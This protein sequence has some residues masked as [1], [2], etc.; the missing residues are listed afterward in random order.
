[1]YTSA[2][3][4]RGKDL[5]PSDHYPRIL[6]LEP[7][8]KCN[9]RCRNETCD[10]AN[11]ATVHLRREDF[12]PWRLF[13]K[14]MDE[15][16]PHIEDL[17]F[18]N[19][20]EPFV[21]PKALDML[22]Y[23][24]KANPKLR[25][26]TSTNGILLARDG[27]AERIVQEELIDWI[28][29]TIGG[30]DQDTY[31][32]YHKS[33]SFEKAILGMRRLIEQKRKVGKTTPTVHW[34]YLI[35]HWND[36]DAHIAEALRLREEIGVDEFKFML[37]S[38]PLAGRS[39]RRAPGT[40]GFDAIKPWLAYQDDYRPD[41]FSE[42][43]FWGEERNGGFGA[44]R[45]TGKQ[46]KF[47]VQPTD[48]RVNIRLARTDVPMVPLPD[49]RLRLPWGEFAADIGVGGH[50][51]VNAIPVPEG[52]RHQDIDV[53]LEVD[54]VFAPIRNGDSADNRELGVM[55]SMTGVSPAS[56]PFRVSIVEQ[57]RAQDLS[58]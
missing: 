1:M 11:D 10:I 41:L 54:A 18:Y 4:I 6:I 51:A 29:F 5:A 27:V 53:E 50:W 38:S 52:Y 40:P 26:T 24:K 46:A 17:Y 14:L 9:I 47:R 8:I 19:Y 45:W 58:R 22:A 16:A 20:G 23:A 30:V 44:Y 15:A 39:L 42:S 25:V 37:T 55:V 33:G 36:S 21:H 2:D 35:F 43:G 32:R 56:N 28:C 48:N 57:D 3:R 12:M 34:R 49:V 31:V 7:S 13:C